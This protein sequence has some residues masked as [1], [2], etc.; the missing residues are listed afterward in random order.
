[1]KFVVN[2]PAS[3]TQSFGS[4]VHSMEVPAS[5]EVSPIGLPAV[6]A[7]EKHALMMPENVATIS[8]LR[9]LNSLMTFFFSSAGISFSFVNP[10]SAATPMPIR[11]INTP[12]NVTLPGVVA[13]ISAM[14]S[15][16]GM[17]GM[18]TLKIGGNSVPNAAQ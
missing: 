18:N 9:K 4:P 13:A 3:T 10:A 7:N 11:Q 12:S 5:A 1:M 6:S 16:T 15:A 2:P 8:P 17:D 14:V